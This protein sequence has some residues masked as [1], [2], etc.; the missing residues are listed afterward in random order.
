MRVTAST[1]WVHTAC[2]CAQS[3]LTVCNPLDCS[4]PGSSVRGIAEA[5]TISYSRRSSRPWIEPVPV[6]PAVAGGFFTAAAAWEAHTLCARH[7]V[8]IVLL[9]VHNIPMRAVLEPPWH[10]YW[11]LHSPYPPLQAWTLLRA[12]GNARRESIQT[13]STAPGGFVEET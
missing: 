12:S 8:C 1:W 9:T 4:L 2:A 3:C 13:G 7:L 10:F 5:R 11:Q 6:S